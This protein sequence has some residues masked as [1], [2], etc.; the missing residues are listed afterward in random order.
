MTTIDLSDLHPEARAVLLTTAQQDRQE[1][2]RLFDALAGALEGDGILRLDLPA[3][4]KNEVSDAGCAVINLEWS[5]LAVARGDPDLAVVDAGAEVLDLEEAVGAGPEAHA[6]L[7]ALGKLRRA[8]AGE[9][10]RR[11]ADPAS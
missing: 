8:L 11:R 5:L 2:R 7:K 3:W 10:R 1:A 4:G 6:A 9:W